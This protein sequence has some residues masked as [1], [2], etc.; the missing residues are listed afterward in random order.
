MAS[1]EFFASPPPTCTTLGIDVAFVDGLHTYG[2]SLFDVENC[3]RYLNRNGVI[4]LHDCN[5]PSEAAATVA[6]SWE[7][8][9]KMN[10]PNWNGA[11]TGDVWKTIVHL[12]SCRADLNVGVMDCDFGIGVAFRNRQESLLP[13]TPDNIQRLSYADLD[14]HR[15]AFLGLFLPSE[16]F[17]QLVS[18]IDNVWQDLDPARQLLDRAA[19]EDGLAGKGVF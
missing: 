13:Y 11:W 16:L 1:D 17:G 3:L 9:S 18:Q 5:P 10:P 2:Q 15:F 19:Q 12:R 6:R 14:E 7:D 8:V 4:L